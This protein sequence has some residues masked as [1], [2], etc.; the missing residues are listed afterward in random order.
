MQ[1]AD[2]QCSA[3]IATDLTSYEGYNISSAVFAS[4]GA[5]NY[6]PDFYNTTIFLPSDQAFVNDKALANF[7]LGLSDYDRFTAEIAIAW[8]G[9]LYA[10]GN[11]AGY[12][13]GVQTWLGHALDQP[14]HLKFSI[15][16]NGE[17][18]FSCNATW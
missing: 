3:R 2:A 7:L 17:V 5:G 10:D 11:L 14:L 12:A 1:V 8:Y 15:L 13:G 4:M 6:A 9:T 18:S 16:D